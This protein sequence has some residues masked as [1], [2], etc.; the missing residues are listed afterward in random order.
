MGANIRRKEKVE[1][2]IE[3]IK[4]IKRVQEKAEIALKKA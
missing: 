4:R 1:N 2:V 3:F